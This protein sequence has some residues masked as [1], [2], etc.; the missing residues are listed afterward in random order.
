MTIEENDNSIFKSKDLINWKKNSLNI[1][2]KMT[3]CNNNENDTDDYIVMDDNQ[4]I[5]NNRILIPK[6]DINN[7][8]KINGTYDMY[9]GSEISDN[10]PPVAPYPFEKK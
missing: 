2:E 5:F 8:M 6:Y 1:L 9:K 4:E 10:N 3:N 7:M